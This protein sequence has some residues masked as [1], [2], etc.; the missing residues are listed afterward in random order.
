MISRDT[1]SIIRAWQ[2]AD[3]LN[4]QYSAVYAYSNTDVVLN[5]VKVELVSTSVLNI[6]IKSISA[7]T[8]N[9]VYLLGNKAD[10]YFGG[11]NL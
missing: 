6:K 11:T 5:G 7:A 10:V 1:Y 9:N 8:P 3:F 4:E 2:D